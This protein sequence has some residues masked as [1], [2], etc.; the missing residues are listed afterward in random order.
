MLL[1]LV[2]GILVLVGLG[3]T[4]GLGDVSNWPWLP[5]IASGYA[6]ASISSYF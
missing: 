6:L 3:L 4:I 5:D 1:S 2:Y